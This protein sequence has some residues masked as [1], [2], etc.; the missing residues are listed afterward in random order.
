MDYLLA[1]ERM[2]LMSRLLININDLKEISEYEKIGITNFLFAVDKLSIGYTSFA[3]DQI[4]DNSYLLINR[5]LDNESVI[6]L[7]SIMNQMNRFKGII[8]EDIAVFNLFSDSHLELIWFQNHFTTNYQSI[9][10][11]LSKGVDSAVIS[12]ELTE[13]EIDEII[14]SAN[15]PLVLNVLGKN[16]IMYSRRTL[17]SNFNKKMNLTNVNDCVIDTKNNDTTFFIRESIYGTVIFNNEYFNYTHLMKKY[18][19]SVKFYLIL[20]LDLD[21]DKIKSIL[22]GSSFGNDGFLNKKTVYKMEEYN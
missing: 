4:P 18:N 13:V 7:K 19:D 12:N 21:V 15:K 9:N 14:A 8:Y 22:E 3:L 11:W 20:N 10:F 16:Q 6:Y 5:V 17:L 1:I 2:M